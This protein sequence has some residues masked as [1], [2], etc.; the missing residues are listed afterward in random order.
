MM[1]QEMWTKGQPKVAGT[2]LCAWEHSPLPGRKPSYLYE[3]HVWDEEWRTVAMHR[4]NPTWWREFIS[5]HEQELELE[6]E[7][8]TT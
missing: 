4:G 7:Y 1:A 2:Y 8:Q 6:L 3:V 5:P